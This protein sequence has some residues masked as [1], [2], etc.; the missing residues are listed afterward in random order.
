MVIAILAVSVLVTVIICYCI[1]K[2]GKETKKSEKTVC[3]VCQ[4]CVIVVFLSSAPTPNPVALQHFQSVEN[5]CYGVLGGGVPQSIELKDN[6][7][8]SSVLQTQSAPHSQS[9]AV[10]DNVAYRT[11][12]EKADPSYHEYYMN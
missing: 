1:N 8:Y 3:T 12:T 6:A 5:E 11:T 10:N 2:R 9:I 4:C 7:A